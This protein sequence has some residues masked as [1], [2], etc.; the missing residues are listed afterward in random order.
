MSQLDVES[1]E[2]V[3]PRMSHR[4][5]VTSPTDTLVEYGINRVLGLQ[6]RMVQK[7]SGVETG[8]RGCK[9]TKTDK[10]PQSFNVFTPF[11]KFS[12]VA[13]VAA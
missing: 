13:R 9:M 2:S 6:R 10:N 8:F 12:G 11:L 7:F 3:T 5:D 1:V 4:L